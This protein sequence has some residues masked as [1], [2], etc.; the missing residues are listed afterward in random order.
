M[1]SLELPHMDAVNDLFKKIGEK[2][3]EMLR[4][5]LISALIEK[6]VFHRLRFFGAYFYL[7]VDATGVY[8]W[9]MSPP[10]GIADQALKKEYDSGKVNY[11]SGVFEAVLVFQNGM[12]IPLMSEWI[13]NNGVDVNPTCR[14]IYISVSKANSNILLNSFM[15]D[16]CFFSQHWVD[17]IKV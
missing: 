15:G 6:R 8:N 3:M 9:G 13:A 16:Y 17:L 5:H 12:Y 14:K 10:E 1:F 2:D 11:N 4:S 7:A